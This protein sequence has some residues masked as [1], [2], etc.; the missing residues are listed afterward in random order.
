MNPLL[1]PAS[2]FHQ[3]YFNVMIPLDKST[4]KFK[5]GVYVPMMT[6]EKISSEEFN[7]V[8]EDL[9]LVTSQLPTIMSTLMTIL[10]R[11]VLPFIALIFLTDEW[12]CGSSDWDSEY[13]YRTRFR[14][15]APFYFY[16]VVMYAYFKFSKKYQMMKL[17]AKAASIIQIYQAD[18]NKRGFRLSIPSHFPEFVE[19]QKDLYPEGTSPEDTEQYNLSQFLQVPAVQNI[20]RYGRSILQSL[21]A[22]KRNMQTNVNNPEKS[23]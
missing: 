12:Y 4:K 13:H 18:F 5:R 19:L 11:F 1:T 23:L 16:C 14:T 15:W 17:R 21:A 10:H 22:M 7:Q 2:D 3:T 9:E 8:L 6:Q 20:R